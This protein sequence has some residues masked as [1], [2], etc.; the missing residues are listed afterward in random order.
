MN[1]HIKRQFII[2]N[3]NDEELC[4]CTREQL[5]K[6]SSEFDLSYETKHGYMTICNHC[7]FLYKDITRE[8]VIHKKNLERESTDKFLRSIGYEPDNELTIHEQ[9]LIKHGEQIDR[10]R[11]YKK[12]TRKKRT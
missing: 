12:R 3:D 5:Y 4:W 1:S 6:P 10:P 7:R 9:F 8:I 11:E 2:F